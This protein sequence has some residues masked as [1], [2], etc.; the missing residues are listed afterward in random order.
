MNYRYAR[1]IRNRVAELL[2]EEHYQNQRP[3]IQAMCDE[4]PEVHPEGFGLGWIYDKATDAYSPPPVD[5]HAYV[6]LEKSVVSYFSDKN[7]IYAIPVEG[8]IK[9]GDAYFRGVV[10]PRP[11]GAV[12]FVRGEN[13]HWE[14]NENT[15]LAECKAAKA[16]AI[17]KKTNELSHTE[18]FA[19][20]GKKFSLSVE[21][22]LNWVTLQVG[23]LS[24]ALPF[25][26]TIYTIEG[27][28]Y[29]L[30]DAQAAIAF[31]GSF[32]AAQMTPSGILEAGRML[33]ARVEAAQSITEV[34]A[35][36]DDR[37]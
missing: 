25:P 28:P 11:W 13:P 29:S 37:E 34:E 9:V 23:I 16:N 32:A 18:G 14:I 6:I 24:N 27:T 26:Y 2:T 17:N 30:V 22:K 21:A 3:E 31:I 35:I 4:L 8:E 7:D 36:I 1:I 33:I 19:H 10:Y 15:A 20:N 12:S 5:N